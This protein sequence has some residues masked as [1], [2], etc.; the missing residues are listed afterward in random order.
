[1]S[2]HILDMLDTRCVVH[3]PLASQFN[4]ITPAYLNL[5]IFSKSKQDFVFQ[6]D[7][8]DGLKLGLTITLYSTL[9]AFSQPTKFCEIMNHQR[10]QVEACN[11]IKMENLEQVFYY[12]LL[13]IN[14]GVSPSLTLLIWSC[15]LQEASLSDCFQRIVLDPGIKKFLS[16]SVFV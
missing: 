1:M 13:C 7:Y 16:F 3:S 10:S 9:N 4:L 2:S 8:L 11:F 14:S 5:E 15:Y 6:S 12:V